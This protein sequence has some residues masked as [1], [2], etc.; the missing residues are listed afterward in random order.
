MIG[1]PL[2]EAT[3][4][5]AVAPR[6][7]L[8]RRLDIALLH[9]PD[10]AAEVVRSEAAAGRAV[11]WIRNSVGDAMD[12]YALLRDRVPS[13]LLFHAR[14]AM[15]DRL[16]REQEVLA[17]FGKESAEGRR[18]AVLIATQVAEQSL[19]LDFD[20][21]VSDLAPIDSLLQRAGRLWRHARPGRSGT[22]RLHVLS[23]DPSA[24]VEVS[25]YKAM[26]R[27]GAAVY[28]DHARL[29]LTAREFQRCRCLELPSDARE[30]IETVYGEAA[31]D[32]IPEALTPS[33]SEAEGDEAAGRQIAHHVLLDLAK[34][35]FGAAGNWEDDIRIDTRLGEPQSLI[36]LARW[37]DGRLHPWCGGEGWDAWRLSEVTARRHRIAAAAVERETPLVR[38]IEEAIS[39][40]PETR[41]DS[42]IL[43]ALRRA[44]ERHYWEG[45]GADAWALLS[46]YLIRR[47]R[48]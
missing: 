25:W 38:A 19:D 18:G 24:A 26:F 22:A 8:V 29:W 43:L 20:V 30:L 32:A 14:F 28:P 7:D 31:A 11:A 46:G 39:S 15:G 5:T 16:E 4:V 48:D 10:A 34:G 36:H 33:R 47:T 12:A 35:Y 3:T 27:R 17:R 37:E 44:G 9:D 23:P 40:W 1:M 41:K 13:I 6:A 21:M 2:A 42:S 45:E